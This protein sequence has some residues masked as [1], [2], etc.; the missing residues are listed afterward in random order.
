MESDGNEIEGW[1]R[2]K[3]EWEEKKE[4]MRMEIEEI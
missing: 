2:E 3:K 1:K 4:R